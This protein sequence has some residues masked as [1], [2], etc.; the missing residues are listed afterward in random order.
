MLHVCTG[1]ILTVHSGKV[2]RLI[3]STTLGEVVCETDNWSHPGKNIH[4]Y[5]F[6]PIIRLSVEEY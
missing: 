2:Y 6:L 1:Y 5:V 4:G 3:D